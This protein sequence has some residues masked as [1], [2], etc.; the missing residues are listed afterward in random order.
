V[1]DIARPGT[2]AFWGSLTVGLWIPSLEDFDDCSAFHGQ[3]C[4]I[5][6]SDTQS[7]QHRPACTKPQPE[8]AKVLTER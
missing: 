3:T 2:A 6:A 8:I 7:L 4:P 5:S 1:L